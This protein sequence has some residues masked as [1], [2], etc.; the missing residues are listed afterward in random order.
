MAARQV[1]NASLSRQISDNHIDTVARLVSLE[2]RLK[3][4]PERVSALEHLKYQILGGVSV[5]TTI[6]SLVVSYLRRH[7]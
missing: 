1:S 5:L 4:L 2:T 3:D 6:I 7:S